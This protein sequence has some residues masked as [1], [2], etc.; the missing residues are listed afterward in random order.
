VTKGTFRTFGRQSRCADNHC[1]RLSS[2]PEDSC[3][4]YARHLFNP[5]C[6]AS[7]RLSVFYYY[8]FSRISSFQDCAII[9]L[10]LC[11]N[12]RLRTSRLSTQPGNSCRKQLPSGRQYMAFSSWV[13]A[14]LHV[15]TTL[16]LSGTSMVDPWLYELVRF[17][18][19]VVCFLSRL[20][21]RWFPWWW[22]AYLVVCIPCDLR[23]H[24]FAP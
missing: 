4:V 19:L 1:Y 12:I 20:L 11:L 15:S 21:P 18:L 22:F 23:P 16:A 5:D 24:W 10:C 6:G 9:A 8:G 13:G 17:H 2:E 7:Q 14:P 3:I